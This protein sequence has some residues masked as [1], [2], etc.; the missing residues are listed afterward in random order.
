MRLKPIVLLSVLAWLLPAASTRAS[1]AFVL[2]PPAQSG[3]GTNEIFF[4]GTLTNTDLTTNFLN[5]IGFS[6]T[7]AA[8]N[9]LAADTNVFFANVPGIL[10]PGENYTDVVFGILINPATPPGNYSGTVTLQ[11]G[12]NI[13]AAG[14]LTNQ[15]FQVTLPPVPLGIATSSGSNLLLSWPSPPGGFV[16]QQKFRSD[17]GQL[18]N[19]AKCSGITNYQGQVIACPG[20]TPGSF[21]G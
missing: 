10:L 21:T 8:T 6:F 2:T 1:L 15:A 7:N 11:G 16:L 3:V 17:H 14:S 9:Y 19:C 4:T 18:D 12:T 13:F 20:P 5:S